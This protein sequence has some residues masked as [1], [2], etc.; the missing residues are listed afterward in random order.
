MPRQLSCRGMCKIA[1]WSAPNSNI[2]TQK[3][4][5]KICEMAPRSVQSCALAGYRLP[6]RF[7]RVLPQ[8]WPR[9]DLLHLARTPPPARADQ[10]PHLSSHPTGTTGIYRIDIGWPYLR[11]KWHTYGLENINTVNLRYH[12]VICHKRLHN[13]FPIVHLWRWDMGH[14]FY[15]F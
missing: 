12:M 1:T 10:S 2:T 15:V 14:V 11:G 9:F 8:D 3:F 7:P 5:N 6:A 13:I 4:L